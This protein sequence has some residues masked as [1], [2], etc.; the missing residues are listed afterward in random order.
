MFIYACMGMGA[1]GTL[2]FGDTL[3]SDANFQSFGSSLL[4][5]LRVATG[6]EW[7]NIMYDVTSDREGCTSDTQSYDDLQQR[8]SQGCGTWVGY[9]YFISYVWI[10]TIVMWNFIAAILIDAYQTIAGVELLSEL[11]AGLHQVTEGWT[12]IDINFTG[13]AGIDQ[14]LDILLS[15]PPPIGYKGSKRQKVLHQLR[16]LRVFPGRRIHFRDIIVHIAKRSVIYI[17]GDYEKNTNNARLLGPAVDAWYAVWPALGRENPKDC[18]LLAH[19]IIAKHVLSW[20]AKKRSLWRAQKMRDTRSGYIRRLEALSKAAS[21]VAKTSASVATV[22]PGVN[23]DYTPNSM[24]VAELA[25]K[26]PQMSRLSPLSWPPPEILTEAGDGEQE[27]T[28]EAFPHLG[29]RKDISLELRDSKNKQKTFSLPV[30]RAKNM[31]N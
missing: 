13:V 11:R 8:G 1:F 6:E 3:D 29:L 22:T 16:S 28:L 12:K 27:A 31:M 24:L 17:T 7:Q 18:M 20:M 9:L 15:I 10:V 19:I 2:K 5:L 25:P 21:Q 4:T 30:T 23:S 14:V 26:T